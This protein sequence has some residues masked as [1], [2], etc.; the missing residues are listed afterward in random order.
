[1]PDQTGE[2]TEQPTEKRK[3]DARRKGTVARSTDLTGAIV[4]LAAALTL[5]GSVSR[6]GPELVETFRRLA[7]TGPT[8]V[9]PTTAAQAALAFVVPFAS[10][11]APVLLAVVAAGLIG[12][13]AQ[14]GFVASTEALAPDFKRIDPL[15]GFQRLLSKRGFFDGL[16]AMAKL[17]LFIMIAWGVVASDWNRLVSLSGMSGPQAAIVVAE[18]AHT[19][20]VRIA[21]A[22]LAIAAVDYAFQRHQTHKQLMMTRDELRREMKEQEGSPEVKMVQSQR[23]RRLAKGALAS[24][25]KKADVVVTNPTHYAVAVAYE[26]DKHHAPIVVAKGADFL[27]LR[28]RDL[29]KGLEVPIV[30]NRRLARALYDKCEVGDFVPRELF[31]PVAEILAYVYK[32]VKRVKR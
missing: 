20:L 7:W 29:A 25:L 3:R 17:S 31:G 22:W 14:V 2:R 30:E 19:I 27:A 1:V 28:I 12:N 26:R 11:F 9:S 6:L 13:V 23:R 15:Q 5:P 24:N 18:T 16:K 8:D 10:A 21:G 32:T 4:L